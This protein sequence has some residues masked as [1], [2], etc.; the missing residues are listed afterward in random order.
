MVMHFYNIPSSL[1]ILNGIPNCNSPKEVFHHKALDFA[2]FKQRLVDHF[3]NPN[4]SPIMIDDGLY[5]LNIVGIGSDGSNSILWIADPH[6]KEGVNHSSNE[7]TPIGLY[8]ITLDETG[9]KTQCSL[10]D[11]DLYQLPHMFSEWSY[12]GLNF[13]DKNWMILFPKQKK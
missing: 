6:I 9:R 10:Y 8:K 3:K 1:E 11:E 5:T 12:N 2:A 4:A 7:K 13:H